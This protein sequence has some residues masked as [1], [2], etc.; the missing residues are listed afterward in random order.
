MA[1][2][3]SPGDQGSEVQILSLRPI[4]SPQSQGESGDPLLRGI[5]C[6]KIQVV[7]RC[8]VAIHAVSAAQEDDAVTVVV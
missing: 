6:A 1:W 7:A 2:L 4:T 5:P 3:L 8:D